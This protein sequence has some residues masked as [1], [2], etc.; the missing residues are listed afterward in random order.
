ML[1]YITIQRLTLEI[2]SEG[3]SG[4]ALSNLLG[5]E[6]P[7]TE[8]V[9]FAKRLTFARLE[10][11]AFHQTYLGNSYRTPVIMQAVCV[12][13]EFFGLVVRIFNPV[14]SGFSDSIFLKPSNPLINLAMDTPKSVSKSNK[15]L[16]SIDEY[17]RRFK[18][19]DL[20]D[21]G[22][23]KAL[24]KSLI[25]DPNSEHPTFSHQRAPGD[26][27]TEVVSLHK[28]VPLADFVLHRYAV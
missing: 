2:I 24:L 17:R 1:W 19:I 25:K 20:L 13:G 22:G 27:G 18:L 23:F 15:K 14:T 9:A 21:L 16:M 11:P 4:L 10:I 12:G 3:G 28:F 7:S 6:K 26:L 5:E 8:S